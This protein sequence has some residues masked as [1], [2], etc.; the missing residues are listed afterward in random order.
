MKANGDQA[1]VGAA[2]IKGDKPF[3]LAAV[4][5]VLI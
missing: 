4:G 1:K 2:M 3:D 5:S